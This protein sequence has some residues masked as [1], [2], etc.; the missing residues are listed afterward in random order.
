MV[1]DFITERDGFLCL[2]E[3]EYQAANRNNPNIRVSARKLLEYGKSREGYWTS[4]NLG[5]SSGGS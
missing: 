3:G 1:S 4:K 5:I 2:T